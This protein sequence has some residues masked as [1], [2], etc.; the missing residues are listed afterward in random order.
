MDAVK[1]LFKMHGGGNTPEFNLAGVKTYARVVSAYD[2]DT[3]K[4]VIPIF[5]SHYKF[6]VRLMGID[7]CEMKAKNEKNKEVAVKARNRL[8]EL[9][10]GGKQIE[11][12][13]KK[14]DVEKT[15]DENVTIVW[16]HCLEFD[17]WGRV[18]A[19]VYLGEQATK[20]LSEILIEEKLAY[21]YMG[22]TKLTEEEQLKYLGYI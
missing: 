6:S 18:L 20:S 7:T 12:L 17:K 22:E 8:Y 11:Q 2:A 3:I 1:S 13:W 4:V 21:P 10:T 16:L 15:L 9:I 5:G 19:N 14:K